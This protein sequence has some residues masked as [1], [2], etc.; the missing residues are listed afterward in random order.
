MSGGVEVSRSRSRVTDCEYF[1]EE[2]NVRLQMSC[3]REAEAHVHA[4]RIS[5]NRCINK[6]TD[7]GKI[8]YAVELLLISRRRIPRIEPLK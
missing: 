2:Q 1:V 5:L 6:L 8:N 3:Y 7:A 4:R